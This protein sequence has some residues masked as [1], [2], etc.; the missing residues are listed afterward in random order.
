MKCVK[1]KKI[2]SKFLKCEACST[3]NYYQFQHYCHGTINEINYF[4]KFQLNQSAYKE[5]NIVISSDKITVTQILRNQQVSNKILLE[6][7]IQAL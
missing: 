5:I 4:P 2:V 3:Q 7:Q 1:S 6:I